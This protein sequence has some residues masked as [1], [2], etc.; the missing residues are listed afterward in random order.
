M[1]IFYTTGIHPSG[2]FE[3]FEPFNKGHDNY[4]VLIQGSFEIIQGTNNEIAASMGKNGLRNNKIELFREYVGRK[5]AVTVKFRFLDL[6]QVLSQLVL[7]ASSI[8]Q[9]FG[10]MPK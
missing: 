2:A 9:P 4:A 5:L 8:N 10:S 1:T 3:I 7:I 6:D